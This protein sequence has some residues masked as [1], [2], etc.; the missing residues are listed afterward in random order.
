MLLHICY[1]IIAKI[2]CMDENGVERTK[3]ITDTKELNI[4]VIQTTDIHG[5]INGH[6][7]DDRYPAN[8]GDLYDF[9][10][11]MKK[12]QSSNH[13][14]LLFDT[15]D[16]SEGTG[17]S[18]AVDVHGEFIMEMFKELPY[19]GLV[20]GNHELGNNNQIDHI[21]DDFSPFWKGKY[22]CMN[23][24]HV[25]KNK[26][27]ADD[28]ITI[29]LPENEGKILVFGFIY[30]M[31]NAADHVKV[32]PVKD[33]LTD[34]RFEKAFQTENVRLIINLCHISTDS[35]EVDEIKK[36]IQ[37]RKPDVP[38]LFLTGH[39]HMLRQ[40][41][42][43]KKPSN[44]KVVE[45]DAWALESGAYGR[46]IGLINFALGKQLSAEGAAEKLSF[47]Y[48]WL[49]M[50]GKDFER[51]SGLSA[52][53]LKTKKGEE[54]KRRIKAKYDD[55]GLSKVVGCVPEFYSRS[56]KPKDGKKSLGMLMV[57]E[58][59]PYAA[60]EMKC[61]NTVQ[62]MIHIVSSSSVR[63]D[64]YEGE[65]Y[66][67]D[68]YSVDPF[69]NAI[70][71]IENV[72]GGDIEKMKNT[73]LD[74][75][76]F[77]DKY[78]ITSQKLNEND[79]YTLTVTTYDAKRIIDRLKLVSDETHTSINTKCLFR[80]T[81]QT[82]IEKSWKCG[83]VNPPHSNPP[84]T[85]PGAIVG[86]VLGCIGAVVITVTIV[87]FIAFRIRKKKQDTAKSYTFLADKEGYY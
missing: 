6:I 23:A 13:I 60:V 72:R 21:A 61:L 17:L 37:Q 12:K 49:N 34:E 15:G 30:G 41:D 42:L 7:R 28:F 56:L 2:C 26:K 51:A 55:L 76:K 22:I 80:D 58:A 35:K 53:E 85:N 50:I 81:F 70:S 43:E 45:S 66:L 29:D 3:G 27:L 57:D 75:S 52:G 5:W 46:Q 82:F 69:N 48:E 38:Q 62:E 59:F 19:D 40:R 4:T 47:S 68:L 18:D 32:S 1:F 65:M 71:A 77:S 79:K 14:V 36:F 24:E 74:G 31:N 33:V 25:N 78:F 73:T 84:K 39:S 11:A 83:N 87:V 10:T 67:D 20:I 54:I 63:S 44:A 64:I 9:V 86:I 8:L 16:V